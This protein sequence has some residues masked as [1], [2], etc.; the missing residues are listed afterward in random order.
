MRFGVLGPLAA[1]TDDGQ[2]VHV[3]ELKVRALLADLVVNLGRPVSVDRLVDDLWADRLP[4]D[5][6]NA[7]Q[8]RVSR[9]RRALERAEPGARRLV[10]SQ[11]PGYLLRADPGAVD[12]GRFQALLAQARAAT[13]ARARA[14]LLGEALALWR[15]EAYADFAD[16][17]FVRAATARLEEE[18]LVALEELAEARLELGEH[19]PLVAELADLVTRHPLRQRLRAAQMRALHRSGRQDEALDSYADLRRRLADELGLDPGGELVAVHR[20]ILAGDPGPARARTN[21]PAPLTELIGREEAVSAV[22]ALVAAGRLV[23]LTG[24]GGVGKTRLALEAASGLARGDADG[25]WL[26]ELGALDRCGSVADVVELVSGVIG[27]R[28]EVTPGDV[29]PR[30]RRADPLDRLTDALRAGRTV[31]VLDGCEHVVEAVAK[32]VEPLLR[33]A[34]GLRVLAT[35]Q[36]PLGVSG[37]VLSAVPPLD[38]PDAVRL[39]AARAAAGAPGFALDEHNAG[40]VADICRRLDGLP[41]AL[42]LA[43]ARVRA[44]GV[45]ELAARI[46]DRFRLLATGNRDAPARQ[47]TLRAMIDWSWE[48]APPVERRVLRRLA[49]H[50]DGFTLEAAEQVC[51]EDGV[52]VLDQLARLVDRSL[53]VAVVTADGSR[54]RLLRSVRAY[55]LER[56]AEAGE[57]GL[58]RGRHLS[59][60]LEL[61][62]RAE[63]HLYTGDQRDWLR[64]LDAE[65]ANLRAALDQAGPTE[66]ALRLVNALAWHW[67]LRGR[68]TEAARSFDLA[69]TKSATHPDKIRDSRAVGGARGWARRAR[70]W[71]AGFGMLAT[72][73]ADSPT[74]AGFED[75]EDPRERARA[76]WFLGLAHRWYGERAATAELIE[77]ALEGFRAVDDRW[78]VAAALEVR[79]SLGRAG[80]DLAGAA[81]DAEASER[82]FR[83]L[84]DGWG[85]LRAG[86][87]LAEL[88]EISGD[89]RRAEALHTDG[90]RLAEEL[91]L[92]SQVS[93]RLSSLG[94][95]ALLTG[96]L[97]AAEELHR[98]GLRVAAE[99]SDRVGE[100]FAE[101]G[102]ALGARRQGRLDRAEA[103]LRGWLRRAGRADGEPGLALVL[104]ELGFV[105]EL[106]GDA[107]AGLRLHLDA[108]RCARTV[109]DPRAVALALEGLAG[110]AALTGH[111]AQAARLL[112]AADAIRRGVGAP[113]PP[114]ERTDVRR[115]QTTVIEAMGEPAFAAEHAAGTELSPDEALAGL[116]DNQA[117]GSVA[118]SVRAAS[119]AEVAGGSG[120]SP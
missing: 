16:E 3:P 77:A 88:A 120:G 114:A 56:L 30:R 103:H 115:I 14:E 101:I 96:D 10:V 67:V 11:P 37:E 58:V 118:A 91:R 105:A 19:G 47:R 93:L 42:E 62:E 112:G 21:L 108:L 26:V 116:P 49:V 31:L 98:R 20:A 80:G 107:Q 4:A 79:A 78:G 43:A 38:E 68:F 7:V 41:L 100:E 40:A 102:L 25:V 18:R 65:S 13:G 90:L 2:R 109:G 83:A 60:H 75:I 84:G 99:H 95:I 9:L 32:L 51:A 57:L 63:P 66:E 55:C 73:G 59:Y 74:D 35:S 69:L 52:D 113:L 87:T 119:S 36:E 39:F 28:D 61:A 48:L 27:I 22:R 6:G 81:R 70:A 72:A 110:T 24:P 86:Y 97:A 82:A 29:G 85:R 92:G 117:P 104:T 33:G 23:T 111:S 53:V 17:R 45:A 94:R 106:R 34:P 12:A 15:G 1:W 64:R 5:P 89:Y 76:R 54:Y 46:E 50:V 44:L 71:R 8:T